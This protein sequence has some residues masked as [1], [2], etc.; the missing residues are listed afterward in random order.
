MELD[1]N[2]VLRN[3]VQSDPQHALVR[4]ALQRLTQSGWELCIGT[5]NVVEFWVVATRPVGVNGLGMTPEQADQEVDALLTAFTLLRD[6]DDLLA[7]WRDLCRRH[8]VRGR[9]AHDARIVAMML[10]AGVTD[11]LTLN[12]G[13]FARYGE[14]TCHSPDQV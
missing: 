1:T 11:L 6:P 9:Q 4:D 2:I 7:R 3:A 5:Q 12:G 13:D 14:I 10:G 8:S